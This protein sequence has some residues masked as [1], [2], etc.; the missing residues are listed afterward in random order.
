MSVLYRF[1]T[2]DDAYAFLLE[3][4]GL[5]DV[6]TAK[7]RL[8]RCVRACILLSWVG[9][10]EALDYAIEHWNREGRA[11]GSLPGSLKSRLS[12]VLAAVS[13]PPLKEVE[14]A[15]LRK[16]RNALT[17]PKATVDEPELAIEEA[18][19]TFDFCMSTVRA[20]F[21]YPVGCQF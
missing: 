14:F 3:A 11:L 13:R 4:K 18:E 15:R 5:P 12:V 17:H 21:L 1:T 20:V 16:I 6:G 7:P 8:Q 10:E 9:L 2:L 19:K